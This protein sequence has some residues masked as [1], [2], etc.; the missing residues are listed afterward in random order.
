MREFLAILCCTTC[1]YFQ[2][3]RVQMYMYTDLHVW[4][5]IYGYP[6][7][8]CKPGNGVITGDNPGLNALPML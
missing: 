8:K 1:M 2:L 6:S 3:G 4:H 7:N 5:N